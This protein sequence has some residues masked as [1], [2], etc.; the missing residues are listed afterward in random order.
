MAILEGTESIGDTTVAPP[1]RLVGGRRGTATSD[2][3]GEDYTDEGSGEVDV[4]EH[5]IDDTT[6]TTGSGTTQTTGTTT[7]TSPPTDTQEGSTRGSA[8]VDDSG[9][10]YGTAGDG[11]VDV[12]PVTDPL[13]TTVT[14]NVTENPPLEWDGSQRG[15]APTDDEGETYSA[16]GSG[17]LDVEAY[18]A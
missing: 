11:A 10:S 16:A 14:V 1:S 7:T 8:P 5:S 6:T 3:E 12:D 15:E 9:E 18:A 4:S 13:V 17:A 2:D